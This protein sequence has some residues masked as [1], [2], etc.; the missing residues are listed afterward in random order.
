MDGLIMVAMLNI[1]DHEA[2]RRVYSPEGLAPTIRTPGGGN[3]TPKILV[4]GGP[5]E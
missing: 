5:H 4:K 3:H 2:N 1:K